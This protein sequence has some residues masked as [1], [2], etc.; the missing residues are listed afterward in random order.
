MKNDILKKNQ[1]LIIAEWN[2]LVFW[3]VVVVMVK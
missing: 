2:V 3:Y 1:D